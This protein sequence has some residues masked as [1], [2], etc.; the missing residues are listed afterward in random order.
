MRN[1]AFK[2]Y[3]LSMD[4]DQATRHVFDSLMQGGD[5]AFDLMIEAHGESWR[6][7]DIFEAL[8]QCIEF[9]EKESHNETI[10]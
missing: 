8:N 9:I 4:K 7:L 10:Y 2:Q 6:N 5:I 3:L 1:R